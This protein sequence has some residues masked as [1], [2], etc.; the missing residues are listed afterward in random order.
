MCIV[1]GER[2][3]APYYVSSETVRSAMYCKSVTVGRKVTLIPVSATLVCSGFM[4]A[5]RVSGL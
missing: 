3:Q 4:S 2:G 1:G 5:D